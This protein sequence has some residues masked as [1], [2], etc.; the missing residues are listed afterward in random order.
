[1]TGSTAKA[2]VLDVNE[3][4][5]SLDVLR[6]AFSEIGLNPNAVPLWFARTLRDGFALCASD[7]YRSFPDVAASALIGLDPHRIT[8]D[9]ASVVLSA[10]GRL[11]AH[12]DVAKG[13]ALLADAGIP[14]CT[15]S[16]GNADNVRRLFDGA[17]LSDYITEHFS[18]EAVQRWKPAPQPYHH[19]CENL[20]VSPGEATM[21]AVHSWDLHGA[22]RAGLRTAWISRLEGA[23]PVIF[24]AADI[25]G[26]DLP[27]VARQ[28]I[29]V[30]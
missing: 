7:D 9:D 6:P 4:L 24:D 5:F 8:T 17:G 15:L 13:L 28:I 22:R 3:T 26:P 30:A 16:Q 20:G 14:M 1:M 18:V 12:P 2:V 25:H 10:F 27:A 11:R 23:R 29:E 19:A 21:V